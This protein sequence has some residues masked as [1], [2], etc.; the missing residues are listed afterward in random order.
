MLYYANSG[1]G[2]CIVE[3]AFIRERHLMPNFPFKMH[4]TPRTKIPPVTAMVATG[5]HAK[6]FQNQT[7]HALYRE[8]HNMSE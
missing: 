3:G 7:C 2:A 1:K 8:N 6:N 5:S 4:I